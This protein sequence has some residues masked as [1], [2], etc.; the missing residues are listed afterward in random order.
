M[1]DRKIE[2]LT[3][4]LLGSPGKVLPILRS[5]GQLFMD[6]RFLKRVY[7]AEELTMCEETATER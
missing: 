4:V 7:D 5:L 3:P 2:S 1:Y 6:F